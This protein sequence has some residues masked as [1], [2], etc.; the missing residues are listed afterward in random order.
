MLVPRGSFLIV[1]GMI[2]KSKQ[3]ANNLFNMLPLRGKGKTPMKVAI[4][5]WNLELE[6]ESRNC[7]ENGGRFCRKTLYNTID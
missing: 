6:R 3:A 5:I 4:G 7:L 2:L 1:K